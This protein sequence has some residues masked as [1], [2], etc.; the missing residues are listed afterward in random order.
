M[1]GTE[2][3]KMIAVIT[4]VIT[5]L[6]LRRIAFCFPGNTAPCLTSKPPGRGLPTM[7]SLQND[8]RTWRHAARNGA[9]GSQTHGSSGRQT[10]PALN[11]GSNL[12]YWAILCHSSPRQNKSNLT[13]AWIPST[14]VQC[15][16]QFTT[17]NYDGVTLLHEGELSVSAILATEQ[18]FNKILQ[19]GVS[20]MSGLQRNSHF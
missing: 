14:K 20:T 9:K 2:A 11:L 19:N 12:S 1:F 7:V 10:V 18:E 4:V 16:E 8:C 3:S 13:F 15:R 5:W 6:G 17:V